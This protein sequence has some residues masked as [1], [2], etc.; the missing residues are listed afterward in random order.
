MMTGMMTGNSEMMMVAAMTAQ[1]AKIEMRVNDIEAKVLKLYKALQTDEG[2][3][4]GLGVRDGGVRKGRGRPEKRRASLDS[5]IKT[6]ARNLYIRAVKEV[7]E[8]D[9]PFSSDKYADKKEWHAR[10]DDIFTANPK[11]KSTGPIGSTWFLNL[12]IETV[13]DYVSQAATQITTGSTTSA[14]NALCD[15]AD[16]LVW[17]PKMRSSIHA[18]DDDLENER[19][20]ENWRHLSNDDLKTARSMIKSAATKIIANL[21]NKSVAEKE[22]AGVLADVPHAPQGSAATTPSSSPSSS[23]HNSPS[24]S[25]SKSKP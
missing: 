5:M 11:H 12:P 20:H 22:P 18:S 13:R 8:K 4:G 3:A 24:K 19:D 1:A 15:I 16:R 9:H 2:S 6:R 10:I 21:N 23:P 25:K 7:I 17:E 14:K